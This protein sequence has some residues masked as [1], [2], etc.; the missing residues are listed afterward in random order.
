MAPVVVDA[1][2][3]PVPRVGL[4]G[5]FLD[6]AARGPAGFELGIELDGGDWAPLRC[7]RDRDRGRQLALEGM[8]WRLSR[9]WSLD[10]LLQPEAARARLRVALGLEAAVAAAVPD[11]GLAA[12][13]AEAAPEVPAGMAIEAIPFARLAALLA[14]IIGVEAPIHEEA[15]RERVRLLWGAAALTP[16]ARAAIAQALRLATQL[17]GVREEKPFLLAEEAAPTVPRARH[18][19]MPPLRRAAM[20]HPAEIEAAGRALLAAQ[21]E[22]TEAEAAAGVVRLLGLEAAAGPAVAAR[23]AML[24]GSGRL[25]FRG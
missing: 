5:L 3:E 17:H 23:L 12:P 8:G 19:A 24:A 7:A 14:E 4:S 1:G 15:L 21:P 16:V 11:A 10:W 13:Y 25:K 18:A 9:H 22:A 20:V 6:L 2:Q